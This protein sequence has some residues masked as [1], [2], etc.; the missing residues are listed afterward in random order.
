MVLDGASLPAKQATQAARR[1]KKATALAQASPLRGT[2]P[3]LCVQGEQDISLV[4]AKAELEAGNST[5]AAA[6][7]AQSVDVTPLLAHGL[8]VELRRRVQARPGQVLW[9]RHPRWCRSQL[10]RSLYGNKH[11]TGSALQPQR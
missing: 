4:Q 1:A 7:F 6:L 11:P 8:V 3:S 5:A 9:A 2:R 10:C